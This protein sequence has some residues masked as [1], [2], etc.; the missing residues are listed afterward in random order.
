MSPAEERTMSTNGRDIPMHD[1]NL[2]TENFNKFPAEEY[3]KYA[4]QYT[5]W[6]MDGTQILASG[7]TFAEM[8]EHL[9]EKGIDPSR[10]ISMFI[11][12][13]EFTSRLGGF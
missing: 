4:G 8:E 7:T 2:F 6:S 10:V 12:P 5:A 1:P 9:Q 11:S 3:W 13:A